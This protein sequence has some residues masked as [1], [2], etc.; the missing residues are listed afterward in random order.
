MKVKFIH[1]SSFFAELESAELLF[2]YF[3]GELPEFDRGK[4]LFVF[5][6]H[7]HPDHFSEKIF[8]LAEKNDNISFIL[9]DDIDSR[10]VPDN[11]KSRTVFLGANQE[12]RLEYEGGTAVLH[13]YK[14]TDEGIALIIDIDGVR[15]YYA[16]DL[17]YWYWEGEPEPWN[18]NQE[19]DYRRELGFM[20]ELIKNDK[21]RVDIAFVPLDNRLGKQFFYGMDDYMRRVGAEKVFPMHLNGPA[22]IIDRLKSMDISEAYRDKVVNIRA[23]GEEFI[24]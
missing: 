21:K 1:H 6:T 3:K 19:A 8:E 18:S 9:S 14:S 23:E 17:N 4:K 24:C 2:D 7:R 20:A 11:L 12:K 13:T 5:A 10:R 22:D 15:I 16:G